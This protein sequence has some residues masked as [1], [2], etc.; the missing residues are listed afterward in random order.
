MA[1]ISVG[2][3]AG[4][5][6]VN[7]LGEM[8]MDREKNEP[9]HKWGLLVVLPSGAQ[10]LWAVT[11]EGGIKLGNPDRMFG[12]FRQGGFSGKDLPALEGYVGTAAYARHKGMATAA[13]SGENPSEGGKRKRK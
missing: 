13:A 8:G 6:P 2:I 10:F 4:E 3:P 1:R 12:Q 5:Y 11:R 7:N 9:T